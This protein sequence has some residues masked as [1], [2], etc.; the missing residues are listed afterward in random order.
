[1]NVPQH[2]AII[3]DGNGRWAKARG[4][5]RIEGHKEGLSAAERIIDCSIQRGVKYL[6]LYVFSTENWKRPKLEIS[7][8]FSLADKYLNR[9]EKFCKDRIRVVISGERDGL[10]TS[11]VRQMDKIQK[12][13][14]KFDVICVNLCINYGGRREL[15]KAVEKMV[16]EGCEITEKSI[17]EH[18][19]N[20]FIPDPDL[21]VRTG[22]H[23]R[24]SNFLLYQSAYAELHFTDTLWP[25]FSNEE[26]NSVIDEYG[27][28]TRNF[29]G[30]TE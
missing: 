7:A 6:S 10:P 30:I 14:E 21:I 22:G 12:E 19:Y 15:C 20:S 2:I 4:L 18:L 26:Y 17:S 16:A 24:L 5:R 3:M 25:D 13:T 27:L 8:L 11:L 1:M 28:R 9:L 29:G 23:K